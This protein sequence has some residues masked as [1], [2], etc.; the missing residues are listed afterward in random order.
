MSRP[1]RPLRTPHPDCRCRSTPADL[2]QRHGFRAEEHNLTTPDGFILSLVKIY[3]SF[4]PPRGTAIFLAGWTC[5]AAI[6]QTNANETGS[7]VYKVANA[8]YTV[9]HFDLRNKPWPRHATYK[10]SDPEIW[11][12]GLSEMVEIDMV[13]AIGFIAA[14]ERDFAA[15]PRV[16][17]GHSR[18]ANFAV[19]ASTMPSIA[20]HLTL[21]VAIG[22]GL[23]PPGTPNPLP[24]AVAPCGNTK[25]PWPG[26]SAGF[27]GL[28]L[29]DPFHFPSAAGG[30]GQWE[31]PVCK[32]IAG[33][34]GL[35]GEACD[36]AFG[37]A[38][39]MGTADWFDPARFG[40]F[41]AHY[42]AY[43]SN[44]TLLNKNRD[45]SDWA[46]NTSV[47][48]PVAAY[49]GAEDKLSNPAAQRALV[50]ALNATGRL[51]DYF[52]H[53]FGHLGL[54]IARDAGDVM[55]GRLVALLERQRR[56]Q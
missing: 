50:A 8:G 16:L 14:H 38:V 3:P 27:A 45:G 56:E 31:G 47:L 36:I 48:L 40:V 9:W 25:P 12:Y 23:A 21:A 42:P 13:A 19:H 20:R 46:M 29:Q 24:I 35:A 43:E 15:G 49:G 17:V 55:G 54:V 28:R 37:A 11:E 44:R 1:H 5:Q 34:P 6:W 4:R 33:K 51:V 18:G 10:E 39:G 30:Y 26:C 41:L 22:G 7:L 52:E 32:A 53:D 2:A